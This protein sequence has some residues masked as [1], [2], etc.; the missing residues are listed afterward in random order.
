MTTSAVQ[1]HGADVVP[2][3]A[4]NFAMQYDVSATAAV[5]GTI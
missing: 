2:A 5:G 4:H 3:E 1:Q